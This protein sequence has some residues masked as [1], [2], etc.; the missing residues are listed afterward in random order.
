MRNVEIKAK[1][2]DYKE[3]CKLAEELSGGPPTIINQDD[4]FYK[5]NHGR[6]KLR[7]YRDKSATLV[8]YD[9]EDNGEPNLCEYELLNFSKEESDKPKLLDEMLRKCCGTRGR[10]IKERKLFMVGQTRIHIDTVKDLGHYMELEVVLDDSQSLEDGQKI[11]KEL[12]NKLQVRDEDL[13]HCAYVD[14]L[15]KL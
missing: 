15:D 6:L 5:V 9:R 10:V 3:I 12:Q 11:A 14:L 2:K 13:I 1:I 7:V 8:R 4:T